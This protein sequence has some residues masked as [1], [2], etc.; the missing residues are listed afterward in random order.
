MLA[1]WPLRERGR[2][3]Q[4]RQRRPI[5]WQLLQRRP[6]R[7]HRRRRRHRDRRPPSNR[8]QAR[9]LNCRR[10]R[11]GA[12]ICRPWRCQCWQRSGCGPGRVAA[13]RTHRR[14]PGTRSSW[15]PRGKL[16]R[17]RRWPLSR[18]R[19][20]R[21]PRPSRAT[22]KPPTHRRRQRRRRLRCLRA[23]LRLQSGRGPPSPLQS[24]RPSRTCEDWHRSRG[25]I[26]PD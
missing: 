19:P 25:R 14:L 15:A 18:P 7:R 13:R 9:A 5:R 16:L 12:T 1:W 20:L 21:L 8:A 17:R 3:W 23:L 2:R 22:P 6:M 26:A 24:N 11:P 10:C 4:L